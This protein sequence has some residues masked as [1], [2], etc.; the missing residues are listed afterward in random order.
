M[1]EIPTVG[2]T[3]VY[4]AINLCNFEKLKTKKTM[5]TN[6]NNLTYRQARF[7]WLAQLLARM[8]VDIPD[9]DGSEVRKNLKNE[10]IDYAKLKEKGHT[11]V[12]DQV[13]FRDECHVKQVSGTCFDETLVF[14][15]DED[16]LYDE[17]I[18]VDVESNENVSLLT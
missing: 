15:H 12:L 7:N 10:W 16:G 3:A 18:E 14:S 1:K 13:A 17:N 2:P 9:N 6:V 11:L 4:N 8:G 5:Q